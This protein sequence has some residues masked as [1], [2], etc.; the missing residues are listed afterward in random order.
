MQPHCGLNLAP[1]L[2]TP[3]EVSLNPLG[4]GLTQS[5]GVPG[6]SQKGGVSQWGQPLCMCAR[7]CAGIH[8]MK[9]CKTK[10]AKFKGMTRIMLQKVI[11]FQSE[12]PMEKLCTLMLPTDQLH[13]WG[14]KGESEAVVFLRI[15]LCYLRETCL[16][17]CLRVV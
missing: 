7:V 6:E 1:D 13:S 8:M 5:H 3:A 4:S 14:H 9:G 17:R 15:N 2:R 12:P 16:L 11:P 10:F